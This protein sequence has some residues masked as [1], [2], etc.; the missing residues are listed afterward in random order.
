[1]CLNRKPVR[2]FSANCVFACSHRGSSRWRL[3]SGIKIVESGIKID[4][5]HTFIT[6][7]GSWVVIHGRIRQTNKM[8]EGHQANT[9]Y[10][11]SP[12]FSNSSFVPR[13]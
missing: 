9:I 6:K 7:L 10:F 5:I 8:L 2:T 1:V 3:E 12:S 13:E 11:L 4:T